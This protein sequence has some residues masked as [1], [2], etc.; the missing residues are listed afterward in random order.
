MAEGRPALS[1]WALVE[2]WMTRLDKGMVN[3]FNDDI[4]T[5]LTFVRITVIV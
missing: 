5:L 1:G 2:D 4:N 3:D